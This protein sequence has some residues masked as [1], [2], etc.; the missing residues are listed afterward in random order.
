MSGQGK[1]ARLGFWLIVLAL[2]IWSL[3]PLYY[4]LVTSFTTGTALFEPRYWPPSL[5]WVN[6]TEIFGRARLGP[7]LLNSAIAAVVAV[8]VALGLALLAGY[9]FARVPFRGS[10]LMLLTVL[11]GTM[12]PQVAVLAGLYE[13]FVFLGL[14]DT[15]GAVI[16]SHLLILVPFS[17]W[18]ITAYMRA[19]PRE[20]EDVAIMDGASP[21]TIILRVF[22][23]LM[24]PG[25][26]AAALLALIAAWNEF[27]FAFTFTMLPENRTAPVGIAMI[28][29]YV[30]HDVP[31]GTLMAACVTVTAPTVVLIVWLQRKMVEG[32]TAGGING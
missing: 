2:L 11:A 4:A 16:T 30:Y 17:V 25:I 31:W 29:G 18:I 12:F 26:A 13:M 14:Y 24:A 1:L 10:R 20:I 6:Y 7:A 23:P 9:A 21:L 5:N 22:M 32:L 19:L 3:F 27:L 28:W 15:L 8:S